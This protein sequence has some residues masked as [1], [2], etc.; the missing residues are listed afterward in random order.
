MKKLLFV[1]ILLVLII[2]FLYHEDI[3][4]V[5]KPHLKQNLQHKNNIQNSSHDE[6]ERI[7]DENQT[8][9][10]NFS[11]VIEGDLKIMKE[12]VITLNTMVENAQN[13]DACN[14]WWYDAN[15]LIG[16]GD[17]LKKS[18][19]KGEHN[20]TVVVR[21]V[22]GQETNA[23]VTVRAYNY[24][25]VSRFHY[26]AYYGNLL[27]VSREVTNHKNNVIIEDD[28][29]YTKTFFTYGEVDNLP[30]KRIR[31]Y[32]N[33]PNDNTKSLFTYN[34]E[35]NQL[36][37]QVFDVDEVSIRY[38]EHVYDE[39]NSLVDFK[40]GVTPED[41]ESIMQ[42]SSTIDDNEGIIY[43]E[44][45]ASMDLPQDI[46]ELNDQGKVIYQKYYYGDETITDEMTYNEDGTLLESTTLATST[47]STKK[48]TIRYDKDG[49]NIYFEEQYQEKG[50]LSCHYRSDITYTDEQQVATEVSTLLGGECPYIDETKKIYAYDEEGSIISIKVLTENGDI[51]EAYS[52]LKVI[53][54]YV[55]E[56]EF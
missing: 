29:F 45:Y 16:M 15:T 56:I 39:N 17:T 22:T 34:D 2:F 5:E 8:T 49:N 4:E 30:V 44:G 28:G 13:L 50:Q 32:Y 41:A 11:V 24:L 42:L 38:L 10:G 25:S 1:P 54:R 55:N 3:E 48:S 21:D 6:I 46:I 12:Q 37:I 31:E 27:Y 43:E 18:F 35:G 7:M 23:S 53:K 52:T 14:Y 47:D 36:S 51:R 40:I 26:D 33:N 20:I 19:P 9:E